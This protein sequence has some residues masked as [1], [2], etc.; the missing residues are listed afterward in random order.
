MPR[1]RDRDHCRFELWPSA[2][3]LPFRREGGGWWSTGAV[4]RKHNCSKP[5]VCA[6]THTHTHTH[7]HILLLSDLHQTIGYTLE[8][9]GQKLLY[10]QW[11]LKIDHRYPLHEPVVFPSLTPTTSSSCFHPPP[12]PLPT[13]PPSSPQ[14][15]SSPS[16]TIPHPPPP[17]HTHTHTHTHT[18]CTE[19]Q[20]TVLQETTEALLVMK[21]KPGSRQLSEN[22]TSLK[23]VFYYALKN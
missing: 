21:G 10:Q 19:G 23:S 14:S 6:C 3:L 9:H 16:L 4:E 17:S 1:A 11:V 7:T 22:L 18:T 8:P 15:V 13:S 5:Y 12:L 2:D 20:S